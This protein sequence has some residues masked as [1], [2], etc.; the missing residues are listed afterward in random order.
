MSV[1]ITAALCRGKPCLG[2]PRFSSRHGYRLPRCTEYHI[3]MWIY[4]WWCI[5]LWCIN[6]LF[7]DKHIYEAV[8]SMRVES[9]SILLI[10]MYLVPTWEAIIFY[11][12]TLINTWFHTGAYTWVGNGRC[13]REAERMSQ[14]DYLSLLVQYIWWVCPLTLRATFTLGQFW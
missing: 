2:Q 9:S 11:Q 7:T 12:A 8:S 4:S 5:P 3:V 1:R 10:I 6:F 14:M 13:V